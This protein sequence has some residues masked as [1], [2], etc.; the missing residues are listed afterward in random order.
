MMTMTEH[1]DVQDLPAYLQDVSH[2]DKGADYP[3][4]VNSLEAQ[5]CQLVLRAMKTAGGNQSH[6]SRILRIGRDASRYKLKSIISI[7][8]KPRWENDRCVGHFAAIH[9]DL[10]RIAQ[11]KIAVAV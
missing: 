7:R 2:L 8:K 4:H 5:E 10:G 3:W 1:I 11:S 6:A 9:P